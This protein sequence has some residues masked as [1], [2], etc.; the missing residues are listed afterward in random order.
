VSQYADRYDEFIARFA[1]R[2]DGQAAR[3]LTDEMLAAGA[4]TRSGRSVRRLLGRGG[5]A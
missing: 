2:D 3:R 1:P 4:A 5:T